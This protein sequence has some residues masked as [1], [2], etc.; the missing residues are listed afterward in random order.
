MS[1]VSLI[2]RTWVVC[3]TNEQRHEIRFF[4]VSHL[5]C[6]YRRLPSSNVS[7]HLLFSFWIF[8]SR[9]KSNIEQHR[10]NLQSSDLEEEQLN[11]CLPAAFENNFGDDEIFRS[12]LCLD[13]KDNI[14]LNNW[15]SFSSS[16][17]SLVV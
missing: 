6:H 7:V 9:G 11:R 15:F 3:A 16:I 10:C 5:W 14:F 4:C 17:I 1:C 13:R 12:L 2:V 8:K